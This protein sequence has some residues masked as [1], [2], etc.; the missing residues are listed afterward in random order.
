MPTNTPHSGKTAAFETALTA[1]GNNT[2]IVVPPEVL[3]ALDAGKRPAVHVGLNGYTYQSTVGSMGGN[4]MIPVSAAIR[5]AT[6][7][8][9][10]DPIRVTLTLAGTPR[11]V[12][13]PDD[14]EA[15]FKANEAA[16]TFFSTLSNSLQRFHIDNINGAKAADTRQR[17]VEKA[18][19]LF[20]A[21]KQR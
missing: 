9:G 12:V 5:A 13:I 16:R 15:A 7:L 21:G 2:G 17:R 8:K 6:G 14:L 18:I 1:T 20:L 19:E 3:E 4:A 11:A 10:G